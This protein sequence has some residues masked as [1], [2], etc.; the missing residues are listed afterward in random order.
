MSDPYVA[1]RKTAG[2]LFANRNF[3]VF[4]KK[5]EKENAKRKVTEEV[6]ICEKSEKFF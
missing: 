2:L 3:Q 6:K 1:G 4:V 5:E